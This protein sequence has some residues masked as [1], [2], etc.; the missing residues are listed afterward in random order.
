M[1]TVPAP[2]KC[3]RRIYMP[4]ASSHLRS[5]APCCYTVE[6]ELLSSSSKTTSATRHAAFPLGGCYM[7]LP[8]RTSSR[9]KSESRLEAGSNNVMREKK[10]SHEFRL[11]PLILRDQLF[12]LLAA[13]LTATVFLICHW[14][15]IRLLALCRWNICSHQ[16][17]CYSESVP[18]LPFISVFGKAYNGSS[19]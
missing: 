16:Q 3:Q 14:I 6:S 4:C 10:S 5:W 15:R 18:D 12:L 7:H 9:F 13:T 19:S 11:N 2:K 8:E 1:P 17:K